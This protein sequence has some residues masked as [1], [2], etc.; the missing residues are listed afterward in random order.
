MDAQQLDFIGH[1]WPQPTYDS[2]TAEDIKARLRQLR[3]QPNSINETVTVR[4][5]SSKLSGLSCSW[6]RTADKAYRV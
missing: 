1:L 5:M 3:E 6:T 4:D 2:F